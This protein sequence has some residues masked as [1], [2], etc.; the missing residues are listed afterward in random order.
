MIVGVGHDVFE[1]ARMEAELRREG[2]PFRDSLFTAAEVAYCEA[3]RYPARHF[4]ARFAAKEAVFKALGEDPARGPRWR[5]VEICN[6]TTGKPRVVLRGDTRNL[7]RGRHIDAVLL[8]MSHT[9]EL[10]AATVVLES[11][12]PQT[13]SGER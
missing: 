1:V 3:K 4:A 10:A 7:A 11:R 2:P 13:Q 12:D 5:E 9:A 8:S 6:E